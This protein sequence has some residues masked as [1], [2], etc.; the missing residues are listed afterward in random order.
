MAKRDYYEILGIP[1][2]ATEAQIKKAYRDLARK[3]HPDIDQSPQAEE[4]FKEINE[5]YQVLADREKR[6][7]YDRLGHA[8]FSQEGYGGFSGWKRGPGGYTYRTWSWS[9]PQDSSFDFDF[10]PFSDPFDI[11]ETIFGTRSPFGDRVK[12]PRYILRLTFDEAIKGCQKEVEV[13]GKRVKFK[14]PAGVD[15]GTQLRFDNFNIVCEVEKDPA[16]VR[17]GYDLFV[18][19]TIHFAK[20]ALGGVV[21]VPTIDGMV[22]IKIPAGTQPGTQIRLKGKGVPKI[23]GE[24]RGDEYVRLRVIIPS[25]LSAK[26]KELLSKLAQTMDEK[27]V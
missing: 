27:A 12:N 15:D 13:D 14:I 9:S 19:Q 23:R 20:A 3:H 4:K 25:K 1:K 10:G 22:K 16:F 5:A 21:E 8:A 18:D 11:F 6:E 7:S 24:E 2:D 26:E 17:R